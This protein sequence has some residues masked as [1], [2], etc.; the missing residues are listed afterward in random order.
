MPRWICPLFLIC[1]AQL[2]S[3]G[4]DDHWAFQPLSRPSGDSI[5]QFIKP[6]LRKS[7]LRISPSAEPQQLLRRLY[8]DLIGL[9]PKPAASKTFKPSDYE[10]VVDDLLSRPQYGERWGRHWLDL[11]RYA[12]SNGLH[13]DTDRPHAWRY[14]DYVINSFNQDKPY[15]RFIREQLAGDEI[16]PDKPEAWIATGFCRN[17]PSNEENIAKNEVEQY[18]LD[19]LDDILS[20]TSQVFLGQSIGC[21]RCHDHKTEPFSLTDYYSLLAVFDGTVPAFV[22][23]AEKQVG[24]PLFKHPKFRDK[25]RPPRQ[26]HIRALSEPDR[27]PPV[28]RVLNR[29]NHTMPGNKVVPA[30]PVSLSLASPSFTIKPTGRTTGRRTALA[31]W[32]AS[33]DNPLTWRVMANRIWQFHFGRGLVDTPSNFGVTGS[34]PSHPALLDWLACELRD[35]GGRLKPIHK[36]IVMSD[37][38]RQSSAFRV[39]AARVDPENKLLWRYQPHRLQAEVIRDSIL[40]ASENLNLKPGGPGIKPRVPAEIIEQSIRN[41]W[42][43]VDKESSRHWRRSVYIY[44]KR[45]L[46][47][48]MLEL[49]D[50]PDTAQTCAKRF[51]STT[52]TQALALMNDEFVNQ[53]ARWLAVQVMADKNPIERM[54]AKTWARPVSDEQIREAKGFISQ[55]LKARGRG[56]EARKLAYADLAVVLFNSSQFV[57]VD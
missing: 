30:I 39:E 10:A 9:P 18:R 51:V 28:T 21:A 27:K 42:P 2:G 41:M 32:I 17:G 1:L 37:A 34:R 23:L 6:S 33:R 14:R 40:Q 24:E 31:N 57:Y 36:L 54:F 3:L 19:Q 12:D 50:A 8:L 15:G 35:N 52:P 43:K 26:P 4:A 46:P 47:M 20:T 29:G 48:P 11:A 7:G 16:D 38:Y 22:P 53:Q 56:R 45:Q 55:R 5:D 25:Y 49:F 44:I 13:Q